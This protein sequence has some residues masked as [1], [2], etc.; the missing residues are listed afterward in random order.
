MISITG[1]THAIARLARLDLPAATAR[2]T[3]A[4]ATHIAESITQSLSHPPG[5]QR[6]LPALRTGALR[7]S[8]TQHADASGAVI[9]SI[10][11]VAV[12]QEFGTARI[13]PRPFLAPAAQRHADDAAALI[14]AAIAPAFAT[15]TDA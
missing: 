4:A 9:A 11:P 1:L 8:I 10:S 12:H 15:G 7:A 2:G 5:T 3:Q 14:A 13:P 6:T